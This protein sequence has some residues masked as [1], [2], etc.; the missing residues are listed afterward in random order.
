MVGWCGIVDFAAVVDKKGH[1]GKVRVS[2]SG[3][4]AAPVVPGSYAAPACSE[5]SV[6]P[7]AMVFV[8]VPVVVRWGGVCL[9]LGGGV[10]GCFVVMGG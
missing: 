10:W 3:G 6:S 9:L 4:F 8:V 1:A 2:D 7:S 5:V